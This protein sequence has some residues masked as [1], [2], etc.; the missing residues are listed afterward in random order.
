[1]MPVYECGAWSAIFFV[2]Y[3]YVEVLIHACTSFS[4]KH[5]FLLVGY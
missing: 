5:A 1:M 3:V 4:N 2:V